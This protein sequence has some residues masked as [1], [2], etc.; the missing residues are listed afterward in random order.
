MSS[1]IL[2]SFKQEVAHIL[3]QLTNKN[4]IIHNITNLVVMP[5]SANALLAIGASPIM[6]HA[7][8]ELVDI[9]D[10]AQGCVINIGTL[11]S[12]WNQAMDTALYLAN[13]KGIP[14]VLDPVGAG[15][16]SFR[17]QTALK[18]LDTGPPTILR[19][20]AGEIL[21]LS[22]DHK[23][24]SKGVDSLYESQ[25]AVD[26]AYELAENYKITVV[27]S[28]AK[29]MIVDGINPTC[30][31]HNGHPLMAKIVG[32]GCISSAITAACAAVC[33][34]SYL[35]A[36]VAMTIMGVS[37]EQAAKISTGPG[38]FLPA[39]IDS[40]YH[41]NVDQLLNQGKNYELTT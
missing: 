19:G 25:A 9:I 38:S 16:T 1:T 13:V 35:A 8:E 4:P 22:G 5:F 28:G 41:L 14:V 36:L 6:A 3:S 34:N 27:I 31:I 23:V 29:D 39:F 37:G 40:L 15:A 26:A 32:M 33:E 17:T 2:T 18:L 21:A 20:N 7:I 12:R 10:L 30:V 11:D 24:R